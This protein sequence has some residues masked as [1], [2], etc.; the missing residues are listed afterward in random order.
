MPACQTGVLV[1]IHRNV[2]DPNLEG[3]VWRHQRI[4]L[5]MPPPPR[6]TSLH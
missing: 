1:E 2:Y 6:P 4:K 5:F 3:S